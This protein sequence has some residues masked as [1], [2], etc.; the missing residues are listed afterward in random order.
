MQLNNLS[1]SFYYYIFGL[2]YF[3]HISFLYYDIYSILICFVIVI[4]G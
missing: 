3:I 1:F 4:I 2:R